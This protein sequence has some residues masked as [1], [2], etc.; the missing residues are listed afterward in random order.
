MFNAKAKL[1]LIAIY[2]VEREL[3]ALKPLF[4]PRV[5]F[6]CAHYVWANGKNF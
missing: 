4:L 2:F 1:F 5:S 3:F 6:F